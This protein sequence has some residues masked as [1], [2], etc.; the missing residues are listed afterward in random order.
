MSCPCLKKDCNLIM[1]HTDRKHM[2]LT[3]ASEWMGG[4]KPEKFIISITN[5]L[6]NKTSEVEI[7]ANGTNV[8]SSIELFGTTEKVCLQDGFYCIKVFSCRHTAIIN[9][10]YLANTTCMI[11]KLFVKANTAEAREI[12]EDLYTDLKMVTINTE[13]GRLDTAQR[14]FTTLTRKL[15]AIGCDECG[16]S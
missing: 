16:C 4:E 6:H 2:L 13:I 11:D 9:R 8:L 5:L 10:V 14:V 12:V 3:D 1:G 15:N 7:L